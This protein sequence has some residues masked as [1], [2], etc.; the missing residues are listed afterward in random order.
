MEGLRLILNDGTVIEDGRAGYSDGF[1]WL[2]ITGYTMQQGADMFIDNPEKT[3]QITFQ[4][5]EDEDVYDGFTE[6]RQVSLDIEDTLNV[7]LRKG[8]VNAS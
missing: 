2:Y 5:G 3:S 7:C 8:E 4:Y 6:C 1:L